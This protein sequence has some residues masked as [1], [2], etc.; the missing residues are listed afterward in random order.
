FEQ[1]IELFTRADTAEQMM[2][3]ARV[4][5][6]R[7][8][9]WARA[10]QARVAAFTL[11][12]HHEARRQRSLDASELTIGLAEPSV[13]AAHLQSLL[14]ERLGRTPLAAPALEL[15]LRCDRWVHAAAPNAELFSTRGSER[16][17]LTRLI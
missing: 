3:G 2:A 8:L 14:A 15:S 13:D 12:M 10:R 1:R 6:E 17:G 11:R 5:I 4:L 7:L 9:A 16:E